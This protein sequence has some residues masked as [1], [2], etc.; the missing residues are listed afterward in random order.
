MTCVMV[1]SGRRGGDD[2]CDVRIRGEGGDDLC[3]GRIREEG[4]MT[5]VMVGSGGNLSHYD[6]YHIEYSMNTWIQFE[7]QIFNL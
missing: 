6:I 7:M 4:E 2:L 5:C 1:G 3:D